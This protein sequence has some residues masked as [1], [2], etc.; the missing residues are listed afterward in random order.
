[1]LPVSISARDGDRFVP[2]DDEL[3]V[4]DVRHCECVS[5]EAISKDSSFQFL[6]IMQIAS[7]LAMT[8]YS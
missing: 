1:M 7:F 3:L 4:N 8:S 5:R 2:R 6:R